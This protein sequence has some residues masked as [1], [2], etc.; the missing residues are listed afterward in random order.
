MNE[1]EHRTKLMRRVRVLT[2]VFLFAG[3][4]T[5][6]GVVWM[7][8]SPNIALSSVLH[9][10]MVVAS[11]YFFAG[12]M[13]GIYLSLGT[14]WSTVANSQDTPGDERIELCQHNR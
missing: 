7:M 3:I 12:L 14:N 4:G 10:V 11:C 1:K 8:W 9:G 2:L 5:T 13:F 6:A